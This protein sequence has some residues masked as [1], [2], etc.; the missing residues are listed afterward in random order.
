MG[1][2]DGSCGAFLAVEKTALVPDEIEEVVV[3]ILWTAGQK[4]GSEITSY[5]CE[6]FFF[7]R[8]EVRCS[9]MTFRLSL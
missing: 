5:A 3:Y 6:F 9:L 2:N 1:V 8:K 4:Q 7:V